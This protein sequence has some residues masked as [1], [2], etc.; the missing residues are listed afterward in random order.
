[1]FFTNNIK[2][3]FPAKYKKI[4][5]NNYRLNLFEKILYS[6]LLHFTGIP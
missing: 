4:S 1:M 3:D 5:M 6:S 2:I